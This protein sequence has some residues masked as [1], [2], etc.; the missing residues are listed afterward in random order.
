[1]IQLLDTHN[2]YDIIGDI[3]GHYYELVSLLKNLGYSFQNGIWNCMDL[4][5]DCM[6]DL[7]E[8]KKIE[9]V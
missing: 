5:E 6:F 9:N 2:Q 3:H 8:M 1:M 7:Y 4:N